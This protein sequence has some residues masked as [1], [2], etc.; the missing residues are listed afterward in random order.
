ME[1][2]I[3]GADSFATQL[4]F[5]LFN[6]NKQ[7]FKR[8][9]YTH[10][11][12][13]SQIKGGLEVCDAFILEHDRGEYKDYE[14]ILK[15]YENLI[16]LFKE[17]L[18]NLVEVNS[19]FDEFAIKKTYERFSRDKKIK[20]IASDFK[21]DIKVAVLRGSLVAC[22]KLLN[23]HIKEPINKLDIL[24][25]EVH[26]LRMCYWNTYRKNNRKHILREVDVIDTMQVN[27]KNLILN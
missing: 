14:D 22:E 13:G 2:L 10:K 18:S 1:D 3:T 11:I 21:E 16:I 15:R 5:Q 4:R 9:I 17:Q 24:I 12:W 6:K 26:I 27:P 20:L 7:V 23:D 8:E 25:G 19:S